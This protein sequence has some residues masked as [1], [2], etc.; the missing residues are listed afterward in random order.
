MTVYI[1]LLHPA[2][3]NLFKGLIN[4]HSNN[5]KFIV[6]CIDRGKV[7]LIA[8]REITSVPIHVIGKH[9][10]SFLSII[11]Q[12]NIFRF[13]SLFFFLIG[14]KIDVG[15]SFGS[16]VAGAILRIK[17][18]PNIHL[19]D[20]PERKLNEIL[21]LITCSERYLPP[22]VAE[23]GKTKCFN[24][25]KEWSYLSPTYFIPNVHELREYELT[26]NSY[27]FVREVSNGSLNY[28]GQNKN[29]IAVIANEFPTE[30]RVLLSLED[31]TTSNDYPKDW[32]IL[33]EPVNDIHSL[34]FYSRIV[35]SSGD[36]MAREGA[37]LGIPS[38]YCGFREMR[39]NDILINRGIL[40]K[41]DP[42]D[43]STVLKRITG[44]ELLSFDQNEL[45]ESLNK[46]WDD[47]N[48]FIYN[49][50]I[51]YQKIKTK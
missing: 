45:R 46:E 39:A 19:S 4:K 21:E 51:K 44:N 13:W 43:V 23:K 40:L 25:L 5:I 18:V 27:I 36:S 34:I 24:A 10:G 26:P 14:K 28:L 8:K 33:Q 50:V 7:P 32:I 30:Y 9:R 2:H 49:Q 47:V 31:K 11:F 35:V 20:D 16:F 15:I 41:V 37:M 42:M 12:A 38:L 48:D 1:D 29:I 6:T 17:G 3:V 22:I